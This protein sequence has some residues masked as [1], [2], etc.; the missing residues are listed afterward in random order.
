MKFLYIIIV[1]TILF[2]GCAPRKKNTKNELV[3]FCA[4]SLTDVIS[5]ISSN[6]EKEN[7]IEIK[8]NLAS[9]GTLARQIEHGATPAIFISANKKWLDYLNKLTLTIPETEKKVAGNSMVLIAPLESSLDSFA[10][11]PGINWPELFKGRLSVGD[12]QY[13]P[14]GS[15]ALQIIKKLGYEKEL[16]SRLLTAKDVRSALMVV[17]MDEAEAGIVYKT[18]ALKSKKV[19]IITE[20]PDSLHT[21]VNYYM[22]LIKE[23]NNDTSVKLYNYILSDNAARIWLKYG[24]KL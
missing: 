1:L 5:E 12:P 21:P 11:S 6:F 9:S 17:E 22:A 24:F 20:F 4:A 23:Q 15:Y 13:V 8:I 7:N 19:K 16:E 14:A 18:D 3:L 10:F 2:T